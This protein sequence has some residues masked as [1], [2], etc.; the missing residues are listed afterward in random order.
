MDERLTRKLSWLFSPNL[1]VG[2]ESRGT[3]RQPESSHAASFQPSLPQL[4]LFS[5][6]FRRT[7]PSIPR[8]TSTALCSP[9]VFLEW[10]PENKR[11][12]TA[13]L[14]IFILPALVPCHVSYQ[15]RNHCFGLNRWKCFW[16]ILKYTY[17]YFQF[18]KLL[19]YCYLSFDRILIS[20]AQ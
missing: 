18:S 15:Q 2:S 14:L 11:L 9:S 19:L 5:L 13:A 3:S 6:Q 10:T 8:F 20:I 12:D 17:Q 4:E 1:L 16:R 7:K